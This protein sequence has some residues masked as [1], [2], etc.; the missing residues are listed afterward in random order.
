MIVGGS[1]HLNS[2]TAGHILGHTPPSSIP[3]HVDLGIYKQEIPR[4]FLLVA[5]VSINYFQLLLKR[6]D[7]KRLVK[8]QSTAW[9]SFDNLY[10]TTQI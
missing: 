2:I 10:L 3:H 5:S 8:Y 6:E 7:L 4:K 1:D 9:T